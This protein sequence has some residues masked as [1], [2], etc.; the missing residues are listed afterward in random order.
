MLVKK[1]TI[2]FALMC[3]GCG[4]NY[5]KLGIEEEKAGNY[6]AAAENYMR[7]LDKK[8]QD[9]KVRGMLK[10]AGQTVLNSKADAAAGHFNADNFSQA[11]E[12]YQ[13]VIRYKDRVSNY[14]INLVL[15]PEH[16]QNYEEAKDVEANNLLSQAS[17]Y[18]NSQSYSEAESVL[19][20]LY[21]LKRNGYKNSKDLLNISIYEQAKSHF[22]G[23]KW[24]EAYRRFGEV[25][26]YKDASD[27]RKKSLDSGKIT[28]A[29]LA[30]KALN[31]QW[32][33]RTQTPMQVYTE[34][35][36]ILGGKRDPFIRYVDRSNIS[37]L[38][39]ER[40]ST[41]ISD[42]SSVVRLGKHLQAQY[43][44]ALTITA[45]ETA[46]TAKDRT[47]VEALLWDGSTYVEKKTNDEGKVKKKTKPDL[48]RVRVVTYYQYSQSTEAS[49][50]V[51][52]KII[53]VATSQVVES[54]MIKLSSKS[55][56]SWAEY[57]GN[58]KHLRGEYRGKKTKDGVTT[59]DVDTDYS[60]MPA[61]V[62]QNQFSAAAKA[63]KSTKQLT[64]ESA[65]K[66][67]QRAASVISKFY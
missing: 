16:L 8:K 15:A 31:P 52:V 49:V 13:S 43:V 30:P 27:M 45:I 56:A 11:I 25:S 50:G 34:V 62:D 65:S 14:Q 51:E 7:H 33:T 36:S 57:S 26:G 61:S 58:T 28:V 48:S 37:A 24:R 6:E 12:S 23:R 39:N 32:L 53:D 67:A 9:A 63:M 66:V 41:D 55:S 40:Y 2:L 35:N 46:S 38:K 1:I 22:N 47:P 54:E 20:E 60:N 44:V 18:I 19:R 4:P 17:N 21:S 42:P 64:S 10:Q 3:V 5:M 59:Y 29:V